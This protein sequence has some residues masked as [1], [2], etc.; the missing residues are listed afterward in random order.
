M[1]EMNEKSRAELERSKQETQ[2]AVDQAN[3]AVKKAEEA[4]KMVQEMARDISVA[5][6]RAAMAEKELADTKLRLQEATVSPSG[7]GK[8][9]QHGAQGPK[10]HVHWMDSAKSTEMAGDEDEE[11]GIVDL[12]DMIG[13]QAKPRQEHERDIG[14]AK[15]QDERT[16]STTS[17][18]PPCSDKGKGREV[19][20]Q[21]MRK[22]VVPTQESQLV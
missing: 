16:S 5:Q 13:P 20:L 19:G 22:G 1:N 10:H 4:A 6:N 12:H 9:P 11:V 17:S 21:L 3:I 7:S 18:P 15:N 2:E 8:V 14:M